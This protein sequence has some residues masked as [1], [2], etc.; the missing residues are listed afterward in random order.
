MACTW[1]QLDAG[2]FFKNVLTGENWLNLFIMWRS[3]FCLLVSTVHISHVSCMSRDLNVLNNAMLYPVAWKWAKER[4]ECQHCRCHGKQRLRQTGNFECASVSPGRDQNSS[5]RSPSNSWK[6]LVT[7]VWTVEFFSSFSSWFLSTFWFSA[8]VDPST[9]F[10]QGGGPRT[11]WALCLGQL[12][13]WCSFVSEIYLKYEEVYLLSLLMLHF[14]VFMLSFRG[15]DVR[16][17]SWGSLPLRTVWT[18]PGGVPEAVPE[19]DTKIPPRAETIY[20]THL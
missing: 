4:P 5:T 1:N 20:S 13:P 14:V 16:H 7:I 11:G 18:L 15:F 17:H 12:A 2:V 9:Q 19:L 3:H 10:L 8:P 6:N